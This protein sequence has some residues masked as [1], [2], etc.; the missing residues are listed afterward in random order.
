MIPLLSGYCFQHPEIRFAQQP[1][2]FQCFSRAPCPVVTQQRPKIL[3]ES[4][5]NCPVVLDHLPVTPSACQLVF[6]KMSKNLDDR[7]FAGTRSGCEL[8][9]RH[10]TD[11]ARQFPRSLPLNADWILF[12]E[13]LRQPL[14]VLFR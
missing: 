4:V 3:I 11:E 8:L 6:R 10:S 1:E 14:S 12:P 9:N 7:P 2:E 5:Q 13:V